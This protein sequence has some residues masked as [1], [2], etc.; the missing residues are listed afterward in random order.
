MSKVT[1]VLDYL[2]QV[3]RKNSLS[4]NFVNVC[5]K[6]KRQKNFESKVNHVCIIFFRD[7]S[8]Y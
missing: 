2:S 1:F 8:V 3:F 6:K 4:K 5:Q 7:I